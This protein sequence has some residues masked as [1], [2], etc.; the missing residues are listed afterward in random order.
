VEN[1]NNMKTRYAE[2][3]RNSW[4][5]KSK[6]GNAV[7]GYIRGAES[8]RSVNIGGKEVASS[9]AVL[10]LRGRRHCC[11]ALSGLAAAV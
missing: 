8:D 7:V 2:D 3:A 5:T 6:G 4:W 11:A 10:P 1:A 9:V